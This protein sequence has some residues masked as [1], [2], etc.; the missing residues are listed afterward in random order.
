MATNKNYVITLGS[1]FDSTGVDK[2]VNDYIKKI[3]SKKVKIN[4]TDNGSAKNTA[5]DVKDLDGALKDT[6]ASATDN[7]LTF[8][9]ANMLLSKT[10][11]IVSSMVDQVYE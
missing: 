7:L 1:L 4:L 11:D 10:I 5:K 2:G 8:Q 6:N 9:A 3:E